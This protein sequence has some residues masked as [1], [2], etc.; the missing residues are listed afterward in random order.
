[1]ALDGGVMK[2]D[3]D[4]NRFVGQCYGRLMVLRVWRER[5]KSGVQYPRADVRCD[6]GVVK[7]VRIASLVSG[8][9]M[10]CGC[11]RLDSITK[12]DK[13]K[14]LEYGSWLAMIARCGGRGGSGNRRLYYKNRGISV[15]DRWRD[16]QAFYDDMGPR[17]SPKHTIERVDNDGNY[18]PSN[19]IWATREKQCRNKRNNVW[20]EYGGK[21]MIME[22]FAVV[23]GVD[24]TTVRYHL[25]KGR[26][27]DEI[28][29]HFADRRK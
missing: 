28:A 11:K 6:C 12:H 2:R 3:M 13:S 10:S 29:E 5:E 16:F 17:P 23:L 26:S 1:M 21:K 8:H 19:C 9:T 20:G 24:P 7:S 4:I 14:S 22:D 27:F 15:C 18:E 25:A